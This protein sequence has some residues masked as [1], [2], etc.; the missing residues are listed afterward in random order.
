MC[1]VDYFVM[2]NITRVR[3]R[4]QSQLN[5]DPHQQIRIK[6]S[7]KSVKC[8]NLANKRGKTNQTIVERVI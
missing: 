3:L 1:P 7:I 8:T 4:G 6:I 5:P 2:S